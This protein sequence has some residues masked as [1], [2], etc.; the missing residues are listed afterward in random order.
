MRPGRLISG[1]PARDAGG[2]HAFLVAAGIFLSRIVGLVRQRVFAHYLGSGVVAGVFSAAL[3]IPNLLQ[4]M[5]GEGVLS[6]SFIPVYANLLAR[7]DEE[8][9]ERVAGAVAGL[10]M[11]A[12]AVLVAGGVLASPWLVDVITPGLS[13]AEHA[14]ATRLVRILFPATGT[15]VLSAWCLG[16]LNSHRRFFLSYAAPVVN[17]VAV[18]AALLLFGGRTDEARLGEWVAWGCVAGAALQVAVQLPNVL[19]LL[20]RLRPSLSTARESVRTVLRN[21]A[22][23]L[24]GRGVVQLSAF[25]D[26]VY[27]S[28]VGARGL[29]VLGYQQTLYLLPI[30]LFGMAVSASEL[31][32]MSAAVGSEEAVAATLRSRLDAGLARL[33]FFVIPSAGAFLLLGDV[34]A[35]ALFQTGRQ[36]AADT[37]YLWFVLAG[38][39]V[40]LLAATMGRL[41]AS[42]FYALKDTRTPLRFALVRLGLTGALAWWSAVRMPG[43]LGL[44]QE[45]GL[46]GITATSGLAAWI[47]YALLRRALNRRIGATGLPGRAFAR[48]WSSALAAGGVALAVKAALVHWRGPAGDLVGQWGGSFL[49]PPRLYPPL[50]ALPI[51]GVYGAVYL[52][53][54]LATTPGGAAAAVRRLRRRLS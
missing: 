12:T 15:L 9:A 48:L 26:T 2:R 13:G 34:V 5:L 31:P 20:G 1:P 27:A 43:Q 3:R 23:A 22:P 47:E 51:L 25:L 14:L 40:G 49:P 35:G 8:E 54:A 33:A 16:I 32:A 10:L 29:A 45:V 37:R 28:Y 24:V 17:N 52:A 53:L 7:G 36:S 18:I 30:S 41:Y 46:V 38:S 50:A 4:N 21:F 19:A 6:S 11:T 42:A 44:P 39:T